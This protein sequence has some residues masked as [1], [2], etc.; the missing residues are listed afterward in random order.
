[1]RREIASD[2]EI[3]GPSG[4]LPGS[5]HARAPLP[6]ELPS[7]GFLLRCACIVGRQGL[8]SRIRL[9]TILYAER[10]SPAGYACFNVTQLFGE[11][12]IVDRGRA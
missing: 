3:Y 9:R 7:R 4:S 1:M 2:G 8:E 6:R 11:Q 10:R 5:L 12:R